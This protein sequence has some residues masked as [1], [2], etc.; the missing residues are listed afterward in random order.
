V[1]YLY[2]V[3]FWTV[4]CNS[5]CKTGDAISSPFVYMFLFNDVKDCIHSNNLLKH[6]LRPLSIYTLL[7]ADDFALFTINLESVKLQLNALRIYNIFIYYMISFQLFTI[8]ISPGKRN[9]YVYI[10]GRLL[11]P[12]S[13]FIIECKNVFSYKLYLDV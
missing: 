6:D 4:W 1:L 11:C 9:Q 12:H 8:C 5:W 10:N 7:F 3:I 2:Y 13:C